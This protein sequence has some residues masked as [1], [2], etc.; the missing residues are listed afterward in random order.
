MW[1]SSFPDT[2]YWR[3]HFFSIE[4]C[5]LPSQI[6]ADWIHIGVFLGLLFGSIALYVCLCNSTMK[7]SESRLVMSDSLRPHGLYSPWISSGQNTGLDSLSLLQGICPTQGSNPGLSHCRRILYQLS[8]KG[9]PK[10]LEWVAYC[11]SSGSSQPRN[12]MGV[13]CIAGRFFTN[14]VIREARTVLYCFDYCNFA[15]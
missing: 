15:I 3:N 6:L 8:H 14:W 4:Y 10:I 7:W 9:S 5:W 11:F 13:S 2:I 12:W 1:L